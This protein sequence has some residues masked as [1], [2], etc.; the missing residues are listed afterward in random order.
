MGLGA[1]TRAERLSQQILLPAE[2]AYWSFL[3]PLKL[4]CLLPPF[5]VYYPGRIFKDHNKQLLWEWTSLLYPC[6]IFRTKHWFTLFYFWNQTHVVMAHGSLLLG[7]SV[8]FG[9]R[10]CTAFESWDLTSLIWNA[11]LLFYFLREIVEFMLL[12][13][14]W[15]SKFSS[16]I[17][18]FLYEETSLA[19][20]L[21]FRQNP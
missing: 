4:T 21:V 14:S 2:L 10:F 11:L 6:W 8:I 15:W 19:N 18:F 7:L 20:S 13:Y 12:L 1:Q 9:W 5:L 17:I 16:F 3:L